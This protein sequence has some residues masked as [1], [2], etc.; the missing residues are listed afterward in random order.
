MTLREANHARRRR[1]L[2]VGK[3]EAA[4][5]AAARDRL[6]ARAAVDLLDAAAELRRVDA[7]SWEDFGEGVTGTLAGQPLAPF[8]AE[9]AP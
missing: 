7:L 2:A 8:S 4:V 5:L 3:A 1:R 9:A 6:G